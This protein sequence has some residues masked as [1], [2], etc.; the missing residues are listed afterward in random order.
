MSSEKKEWESM[1]DDEVLV[2]RFLEGDEAAFSQLVR[3]WEKPM[4]SFV[5]R[6]ISEREESLDICQEVFTIV[7]R[8]VRE[9]KEKSRFSAWIY[10]IALNQCRIHRREQRGKVMISLDVPPDEATADVRAADLPD[11]GMG[12]E[13]RLSRQELAE[14]VRAAL[15]R[16]TPEQRTVIIMKEYQGLKFHEIAEILDCPVSTIKS[17]MYFG[18]QALE[19]ELRRRPLP[20]PSG[21]AGENP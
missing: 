12:P 17:R 4:Y 1:L 7:F 11:R 10:K 16:L 20:R 2:R 5:Y 18:L 15:D 9:L 3:Q 21:P 14:Q 13:E 6:F 19:K 8:K